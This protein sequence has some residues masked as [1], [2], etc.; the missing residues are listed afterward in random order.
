[1]KGNDDSWDELTKHEAITINCNTVRRGNSGTD[2]FIFGTMRVS[3]GIAI[4]KFE[5]IKT[6]MYWIG[7]ANTARIKPNSSRFH[8]S[9][10]NGYFFYRCS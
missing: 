2:P 5:I 8:S 7:V 9:I 6:Q 4:W 3:Q 10:G 1:M